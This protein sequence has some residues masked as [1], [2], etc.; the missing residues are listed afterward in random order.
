MENFPFV[1]W[2]G[3]ESVLKLFPEMFR[4]GITKHVSHIQGTDQ[5]LSC[6]DKSVQNVCPSCKCHDESISHITQCRDP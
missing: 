4:V 6:I 3:M 5:Q 1:Y 2:E